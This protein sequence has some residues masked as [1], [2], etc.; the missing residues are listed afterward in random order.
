[1]RAVIT[2]MLSLWLLS[3][4]DVAAANDSQAERATL[5]GL[6][7][8]SVV[9]EE[10]SPIAEKSGLTTTALQADV[11]RR[12][13]QAG[14]TLTPDA[15][16]YLYVHLT[17]ADPGGAGPVP[18]VVEV[19]LMQEVTLP[20]GLRTRT[21]LQCPTWWVNRLGLVSPEGLR[22]AVTDRVDELVDQFVRAYQSVNAGAAG[23]RPSP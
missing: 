23:P 21:P 7:P 18:Y 14:I 10:L 9:V 11:E 19:T 3:R 8:V 2:G 5:A 16:A 20:R 6:T 13:R 15:D 17:V 22:R 4:P 12:F 1:M